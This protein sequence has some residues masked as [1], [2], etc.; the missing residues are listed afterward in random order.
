MNRLITRMHEDKVF[1]SKVTNCV[2]TIL[3]LVSIGAILGAGYEHLMRI[4]GSIH[5][6]HDKS[7]RNASA[8]VIDAAAH[9][10]AGDQPFFTSSNGMSS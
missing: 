3:T 9:A 5:V 2:M 7:T 4:Q 8:L 10:S 6:T 1:F